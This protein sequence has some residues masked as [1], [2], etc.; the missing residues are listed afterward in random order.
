MIA[1]RY[2]RW[3]GTQAEFTLDVKTALEAM[4]DLMMEGLTAQEALEWMR[5]MGFELAGL[6]MRVMGLDEIQDELRQALRDLYDGYSMDR[7]LPEIEERLEEI[8]ASEQLTLQAEHG[9]ESA[10]MNDFLDRRHAESPRVSDRIERFRDYDFQ[11]EQAGRDFAE[12]LAELDAL[13]ELEDFL[14]ER[15]ERFR[16]EEAAD[17][18]EAQEIR[19]RIQAIEQL[20]QQL[21][22]GNLEGISSESLGELLGDQAAESFILIQGL[23]SQMRDEGLLRGQGDEL[24]LTPRAIRQMGA[25]AL[26]DVYG[27]LKRD[28]AGDHDSSERGVALPRPDETRPWQYGDSLDLDIVKTV[29]NGVKRRVAEGLPPAG[30]R[31][32]LELDDFEV[33]ETD[34]ITQTTTILLLDLSWSMSWAGRFPAAKRVAMALDHLV[35]TRYPRDHFAIVGFSTRAREIPIGELPEVCWDMGDPFTNLQQGLMVAEDLIRK[36]PSSSPQILV[37]TDGQPTA[38]LDDGQLRVEWPNGLGGI[39]PH[40]VAATLNQVRRITKRGITINT[41]MLDDAPELVGF[42]ERMTQINHGRA[43]YTHPS[44]LGS[45]M[46]VDYV[47]QRRRRR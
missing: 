20:M 24:E 3:D 8:L 27:M 28:R 22:S 2:S 33:R 16:G 18:D 43:F 26:A 36:V 19:E 37:I 38:Y 45:F 32:S 34:C 4:S 31:V 46:M 47:S 10:A 29:M 30:A 7:A 25:S 17:Y 44:K 9:Y 11:N 15:G 12:L 1:H 5:R 40:A 42:V 41:F 13:K 39:S 14:Q 6:N 21:A 35:R 23:E